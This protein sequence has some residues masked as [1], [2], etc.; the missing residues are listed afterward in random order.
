MSSIETVN[1]TQDG[2]MLIRNGCVLS[3]DPDVGDFARG[4]VL[5]EGE[6]ITKIGPDLSSESSGHGVIVIDAAGCIVM[7]GFVDTHRH[8]WQGQLRRMIPNVDT[9]EGLAILI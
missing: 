2:R 5:V 8:M 9:P 3:M 4:D 1:A 6:R 7:P